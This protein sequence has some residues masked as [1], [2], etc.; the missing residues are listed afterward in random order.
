MI[1]YLGVAMAGNFQ[2]KI[3]VPGKQFQHMIQKAAA[4][5]NRGLSGSIQIDGKLNLGFLSLPLDFGLTHNAPLIFP[6]IR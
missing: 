6:V 5:F 4:G 2:I 3:A 1:V